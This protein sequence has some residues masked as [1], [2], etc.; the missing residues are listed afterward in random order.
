MLF[1]ELRMGDRVCLESEE[2]RGAV[3]RVVGR[4]FGSMTFDVSTE[5]ANN[6]GRILHGVRPA[7]LRRIEAS[8]K[9]ADIR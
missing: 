1:S 2:G 5:D 3:W 8:S 6:P 4:S 9:A 7:L